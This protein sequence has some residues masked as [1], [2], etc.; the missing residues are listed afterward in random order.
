MLQYF[1]L[2]FWTQGRPTSVLAL[3]SPPSST[4][5]NIGA[6][7][8]STTPFFSSVT[9]WLDEEGLPWR[10]ADQGLFHQTHCPVLDVLSSAERSVRLHLLASPQS[11]QDCVSCTCTREIMQQTTDSLIHLHQDVWKAQE[12]IVKSRLLMRLGRY[13]SRIYA[14][15]TKAR[16]IPADLALPFLMEHHLWSAV[17]SK[18]YYGL[19]TKDETLVAVASFGAR[20]KVTRGGMTHRS[21]ELIRFCTRRDGMVVGAI[22]KLLKAFTRDQQPDD[23]VTVVDRDWGPGNGWHGL[24]FETVH[25]MPPLAMAVSK[26]DG[27]RRHLVG[28]GITRPRV[29]RFLWVVVWVVGCGLV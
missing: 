7:S 4:S 20:R 15:Q 10:E 5:K 14:R 2:L 25:V 3:S 6:V 16:R 11:A 13:Q 1:F 12:P 8:A 28:A 9:K 21:H 29:R 18:Y 26:E 27:I 24:G 19:Y 23:I 22:S 17:K